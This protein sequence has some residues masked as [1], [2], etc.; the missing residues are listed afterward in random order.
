[1]MLIFTSMNVMASINEIDSEKTSVSRKN[2]DDYSVLVSLFF[3][4]ARTGNNE[5]IKKF[6]DSGF[7]INQK[8]TQSYTA[9][10][11]AA[12]QGQKQTVQ[13]LLN[14]GANACLKDKRGNT[15][16]LG[17]LLKREIQI[18]KMLY[19]SECSYEDSKNK[20]GLNLKEFADIFGQT[21]VLKMLKDNKTQ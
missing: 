16:L 21:E 8:N 20:A 5:V 18:A 17:A 13:L 7:P 12:Y 9:L 3:D 4:A 19:Q 14:E 2:N 10:M 11:I 1:M 15:A 6:V